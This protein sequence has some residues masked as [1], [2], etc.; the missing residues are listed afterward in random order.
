MIITS[1]PTIPKRAKDSSDWFEWQTQYTELK[2]FQG[3]EREIMFKCRRR[4]TSIYPCHA[5]VELTAIA[6]H[7][8]LLYYVS[9]SYISQLVLTAQVRKLEQRCLRACWGLRH[10]LVRL[11][12]ESRNSETNEHGAKKQQRSL[13]TAIKNSGGLR[14]VSENSRRMDGSSSRLTLSPLT[15]CSLNQSRRGFVTGPQP[16]TGSKRLDPRRI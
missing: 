13:Y 11:E 5:R 12:M 14:N 9:T 1:T 4:P 15:A 8:K 3:D 10:C 2:Q 7:T 6:I 16:I